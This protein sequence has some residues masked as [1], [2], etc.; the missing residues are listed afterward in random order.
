MK[1]IKYL[2]L[3][4]VLFFFGCSKDSGMI[5]Q[6]LVKTVKADKKG[7]KSKASLFA[8]PSS[9]QV[10]AK[11]WLQAVPDHIYISQ[12]SI[13][14]THE[15]AALHE[16]LPNTARCQWLSI[17]Q[18]LNIGVRYLD[19]RCR[20]MNNKFNIYHGIVNQRQNFSDI[21]N[22]CKQFLKENPS[23]FIF[24]CVKEEYKAVNNSRPFYKTFK[25][26]LKN[27]AKDI[28]Y[29]K[30]KIPTLASVRGK[31]VLIRRFYAPKKLGI[32]ARYGWVNNGSSVINNGTNQ[33]HIQDMYKVTNNTVKW[34]L[35]VSMFNKSVKDTN[36][37]NLYLNNISGY[38]P[39]WFGI[40]NITA[41]SND[42]NNKLG[43]YLYNMTDKKKK[44]GIVGID[45]IG[46]YR[47][48]QIY[49][50]QNY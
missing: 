9:N 19:I 7:K 11:N 46:D 41:V 10:T 6:E 13:P 44:L 48:K 23:E 2:I 35:V 25:E 32:Q 27:E 31:I 14:G 15:S 29:T 49:T 28:F 16:G 30:N 34:N 17:K 47:A 8:R 12:L 33:L 24:M 37:K 21:L 26:Y 22:A 5:P 40:P 4:T 42:L 36:P 18:Q 50:T 3:A 20:H 43:L 39:G 1:A 38:K 45:F